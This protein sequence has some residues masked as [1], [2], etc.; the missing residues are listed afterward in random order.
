MPLFSL[1]SS[2]HITILLS[3][4]RIVFVIC[5]DLFCRSLQ[6]TII[7]ETHEKGSVMIHT[8]SSGCKFAFNNGKMGDTSI[9]M[10]EIYAKSGLN[11]LLMVST[12]IT[13]AVNK[14]IG[15]HLP[16]SMLK[17]TCPYEGLTVWMNCS[18]CMFLLH[19]LEREREKTGVFNSKSW[20]FPTK[21]SKNVYCKTLRQSCSTEPKKTS[22]HRCQ[23]RCRK[24][25]PTSWDCPM[26]PIC[27]HRSNEKMVGHIW[28]HGSTNHKMAE[29]C[30]S[31]SVSL[32]LFSL[33]SQNISK[34]ILSNRP[35]Y[36]YYNSNPHTGT[37]RTLR[38]IIH[39]FFDRDSVF[40]HLFGGCYI[41]VIPIVKS[42]VFL[43]FL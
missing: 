20:K 30:Y 6:W 18:F 13:S 42:H 34:Q 32:M 17:I 4:F 25:Y 16:S 10:C 29:S 41:T 21:I 39:Y 36:I 43:S 35:I 15:S 40:L 7:V 37:D 12:R 33:D 3:P 26:T 8:E 2:T 22:H 5:S 38:K 9:M 11:M 14:I 1:I 23:V 19:F 24:I 31:Q 27:F 28:G